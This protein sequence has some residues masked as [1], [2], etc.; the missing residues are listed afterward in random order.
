MEG[1]DSEH[2][3][4]AVFRMPVPG[5]QNP[6]IVATVPGSDPEVPLRLARCLEQPMFLLYVLHTSRGEA[7]LGRYQSPE[8]SF[9]EVEDFVREFRPFLMAD[10]RFDLWI[11]S[12]GQQATLVWDRHNLL[13][14][15]GPLERYASELGSL[16]F[17]PGEPS[18][19]APHVHY[20]HADLDPLARQLISR[21]HW[22]HSPLRAE[23]EQ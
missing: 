10:A 21:F 19:P 16:G 9:E 2:S 1:Q 13:Y 4:P 14:A 3:H 7:E 15:Y 5:V 8:L 23:D 20:Y 11:Y 17:E 22:T 12:P 6:R 18:V